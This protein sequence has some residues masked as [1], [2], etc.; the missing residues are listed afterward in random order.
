VH[1]SASLIEHRL[2]ADFTLPSLAG[3]DR[4]AADRVADTIRGL[5]LS[6][7]RLENVRTA[8]AEATLNAIEHGN[9]FDADKPVGIR[10]VVSESELCVTVSDSGAGGAEQPVA[11]DLSAKLK[12]EQSPRGWGLFL[13]RNMVDECHDEVSD[14]GHRVHLRM[15]L[16]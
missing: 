10:V 7:A 6:E 16:R 9:H 11:P 5:P 15:R 13:I 2:L 3:N 14:D 4:V 8:V 1:T 12:G